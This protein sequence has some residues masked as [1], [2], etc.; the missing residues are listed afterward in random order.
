MK[1]E[2]LKNWIEYWELKGR[3]KEKNILFVSG[4]DVGLSRATEVARK[5]I[6]KSIMKWLN[7]KK[8]DKVLEVGCGAGLWLIPLSKILKDV[9]GLDSSKSMLKRIPKNI[10]TY[11]SEANKLSFPNNYFDKVFSFSVFQYFPNFEYA[12]EVIKEMYRVC[13]YEGRILIC[14]IPNINKKALYFKKKKLEH[15]NL[16]RLFY[17]KNF[18]KKQYKNSKIFDHWFRG[19]DN[20]KYRFNIIINKK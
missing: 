18:F 8:N 19:Y 17:S 7:L 2:F 10:K 4:Y 13:K 12:R 1:V 6:F 9:I 11:L 14:D 16:K 3:S 15:H 20:S 5:T